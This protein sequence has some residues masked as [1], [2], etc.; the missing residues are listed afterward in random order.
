MLCI[1]LQGE[2]MHVLCC[3]QKKKR[4]DLRRKKA[5]ERKRKRRK[6]RMYRGRASSS[7]EL[8]RHLRK[9]P[10]TAFLEGGLYLIDLPTPFSFELAAA[11][12]GAS[13]RGGR[14]GVGR[15]SGSLISETSFPVVSSR[16]LGA[17]H[18]SCAASSLNT[19]RMDASLLGG[20][21]TIAIATGSRSN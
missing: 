19:L 6:G 13:G 1:E 20:G 21:I 7:P 3:I 4:R 11:R 8:C 18:A 17:I 10:R 5:K 2:Y 14:A 12:G 9:K 15:M 16:L